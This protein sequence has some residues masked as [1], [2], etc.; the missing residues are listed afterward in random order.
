MKGLECLF[1]ETLLAAKKFNLEDAVLETVEDTFTKLGFLPMAKMLV[2]THA[3]HCQR[4]SVEMQG[5][6]EML[7]EL[8]LPYPMSLASCELLAASG[9]AGLPQHYQSN[10]PDS[11]DEV[12]DKLT[13]YYGEK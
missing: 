11:S 4:R 2:T 3:V 6:V 7:K 12:L 10:V 9:E 13:Q 1:V 5:A 8:N